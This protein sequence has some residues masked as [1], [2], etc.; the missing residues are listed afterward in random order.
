LAGTGGD[1]MKFLRGQVGIGV[2]SVSMQVGLGTLLVVISCNSIICIFLLICS[3][4]RM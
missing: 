1:G 2:I 3:Y 4:F